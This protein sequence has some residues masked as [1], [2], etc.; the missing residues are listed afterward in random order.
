MQLWVTSIYQRGDLHRLH[1]KHFSMFE[2]NHIYIYIYI[3]MKSLVLQSLNILNESLNESKCIAWM[4][5][6]SLWIKASAKCINV[7]VM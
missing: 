3:C 5:C 6:K 1:L 4:H 2:C 7:N